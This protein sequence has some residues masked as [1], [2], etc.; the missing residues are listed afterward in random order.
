MPSLFW[1]QFGA[2]FVKNWIVLR[3]H[4][5][6]NILR[7][8]VLPIAYGI[9]LAVAQVFLVKPSNFGIGNPISVFNLSGQF[10]PDFTLYWA[11]ATTG[12]TNTFASPS[13]I[14][15]R[16]TSG[17]SREQLGAVKQAPSADVI[18]SLCPQNFNLFSECWAGVV[19]NSLPAEVGA[20]V[21]YTIRADGGLFHIDVVSHNSDYEKRILPLQWAIDSAIIEL[22]SGQTVPTPEEWPFTQETNEEQST[23][24]RLSYIRGLRTLLVLALFIDFVGIV[25]QLPGSFM[26]ERAL[27]LTA[28]LKV[29]GLL[30]S[31]RIFSW[32]VS[33]TLAYLPAWT[34][35]SIIWHFQI[36]SGTNG[37][38]VFVVHLIMGLSLASWSLFVGAPFGNS[39]QLAAVVSTFLSIVFAI[40]ALVL[41]AV[42]DGTSFIFTLVFPPAYYIFA[43][44]SMAGFEVHQIPTSV[45]DPD[46]DSGMRL[47]PNIV[48]GIIDI[49][50]WPYLAVLLERRLYDARN[51]PSERQS[52]WRFGR[53][54]SSTMNIEATPVIPDPNT[55]ISVRNLRKTFSPPFFRKSRG[56]VVA[57]DDLSFEVPK[58]GIFVLLGS[59]G[60]GKSTTLSILAGLLGRTSGTVTFQDGASQPPRGALGI[61][62]QKNVL[63]P[64]LT[65]LQTLRVWQAVKHSEAGLSGKEDLEQLLLDCD[66]IGKAGSNANTL[67]G[68]QKRKLQLAI[69]L[70][71]GSKIVF[72]DECTSGVDPLSRRALWRTLTN[73]RHERTVIFTTHF[74]DEADL[75]A[76]EIAILAAPGKL[77]AAGSPVSLKSSL[78]EGYTAIV[79]FESKSVFDQSSAEVLGRLRVVA[80]ETRMSTSPPHRAFYHLRSKET[81]EVERALQVLEEHGQDLGIAR[82]DIQ[83]TSIEDIFLNLM[84]DPEKT[85]EDEKVDPVVEEASTVTPTQKSDGAASPALDHVGVNLSSTLHLS[86]GR[87]L[88]PLRQAT[89]IFHKR[90][91]VFRRSWLTPILMLIVAIAGAC[92]PLFFMANR[93]QSC[94]TRFVNSTSLSLYLPTS[95]ISFLSFLDSANAIRQYPPG[96]IRELGNSTALIA[97][98]NY[99]SLNAFTSGI[100]ANYRNLT[101]GGISLPDTNQALVAWEASPP[102]ITG[103]IM[104]NLASN[105]LFNRVLN[106]GP[107]APTLIQA[108]YEA[109]PAVDTETLVA[110]KW[111]G[112]FGAAMAVYPAFFSLYVSRERRSSVQAMQFSNGLSNPVGL[113]LGH[114][115]FDSIFVVIVATIIT[116]IFAAAS[117]QF[118]GLGFVWIILTLYGVAGALFAYVVSLITS[119]PLAAFAIAAGYQIIMFTAY[120]AAYLLTLTYA[121]T[122]EAASIITII[123]FTLSIVAPVASILRTAFVSVN[124]FSLACTGDQSVTAS[125]LG[126]ITRFGGPILYLI[127]YAIALFIILVWTDSGSVLHRAGLRS[128]RRQHEPTTIQTDGDA[129]EVEK[130]DHDSLDGRDALCVDSITKTFGSGR[131]AKTVVD[132]VSLGVSE[133]TIFAL[134]GPNGAGKTTTFN[135]IRGEVI[136]ERGDVLINGVS[137]IR[138]PRSARLALGVCPQF[139]AIDTQLT[140]REHLL[141]YARLKGLGRL[142]GHDVEALMEAT[143]LAQYA[144][145]LAS[146]LSGGNQR[147]LAL[148]IALIGNPSVVLI[149]EFSTGI[150]AKMKR[151]MWITLRRVAVGKAIV[152]TTHSMEEAAALAGRVGIIAKRLLV[153]G[154]TDAL[155]D[156]FAAYEVHLSARTREDLD[157]ARGLIARIPGAR[158]ADDVAT[159]L[160]VP[161][162][163]DLSLSQ[164]FHILATQSE[165]SDY[166]VERASLESVFLKVIRDNNVKESEEEASRRQSGFISV[167]R[168]CFSRT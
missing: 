44:R 164:L 70:V 47:L 31:A 134:L 33:I 81:G 12:E 138:H 101:R 43:L 63:F 46:P 159:R 56:D 45:V 53:R 36:F 23:H 111:V 150:D 104:L 148:A 137:V 167:L 127:V 157:R 140:V 69:G 29:M 131:Q 17:F 76:D 92:V 97:G 113:W 142:A 141:V 123:H 163:S 60:A 64:E 116:I 49:F 146:Q 158:M 90:Y 118:H 38:L 16:V 102:G 25:Y 26:G 106:S 115:M 80:P 4:L 37:G 95:P 2:L 99:S 48:A 133:D 27:G 54:H 165:F 21:N 9:F 143:A 57:V 34:I 77:V 149:D 32:L 58:H 139:T 151:D 108:Y 19:F 50:L 132:D 42:G 8:L 145:R 5:L 20:P 66:L 22:R 91:L 88:S 6:L 28:H 124:L 87:K 74:L 73:V 105:L 51:P 153:S 135:I 117:N 11:D 14:M 61:V 78:G 30:D 161:I 41:G 89:T 121:K 162:T 156:R 39:P 83:G 114:A 144:D 103:P 7:C 85:L 24:T 129:H 110:L 13:E 55:A 130:E 119:S 152:I 35:V 107:S 52:R 3:S 109:F 18:P 128:T 79:S 75:L 59:N 72:V 166:S 62:P 71:G 84:H 126:V 136:P 86:N 98:Q 125:E 155:V 112:F 67:S 160:E 40:F 100:R 96:L 10:D 94:T 120:I 68:G 168:S 15:S 1:R 154:T 65:C 147:K 93:P 82:Y 122:S